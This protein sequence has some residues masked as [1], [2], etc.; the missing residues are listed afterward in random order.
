MEEKE[1]LLY[2]PRED[3]G[4]N[5]SKAWNSKTSSENRLKPIGRKGHWIHHKF[6]GIRELTKVIKR[7]VEKFRIAIEIVYN[8]EGFRNWNFKNSTRNCLR[9][10]RMVICEEQKK[11]WSKTF[12]KFWEEKESLARNQVPRS[13]QFYQN[14]QQ[15]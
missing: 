12:K 7:K 6:N 13:P 4:E 2:V 14:H 9:R 15:R 3:C 10:L 11:I 8:K 5:K 1:I